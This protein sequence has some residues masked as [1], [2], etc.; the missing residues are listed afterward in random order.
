MKL[1]TPPEQFTP[2]T[3]H[4][5]TPEDFALFASILSY[6]D[7]DDVDHILEPMEVGYNIRT[8][9]RAIMNG[10][11]I[12]LKKYLY[13][14]GHDFNHLDRSIGTEPVKPDTTKLNEM[15]KVQGSDGNWNH[16]PYMH[17]MYNGM[18]YMLSMIEERDPTFREAPKKW[19]DAKYN[20]QTTPYYLWDFTND[21][22]F[23]LDPNPMSWWMASS[24]L[25]LYR[26]NYTGIHADVGIVSEEEWLKLMH[27]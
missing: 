23:K 16:D 27:K 9:K 15:L 19:L 11:S 13:K 1:T 2:M 26:T 3:I 6:I 21:Q 20:D 7:Q 24:K 18:E 22:P 8:I 5:E 12:D 25:D 4:L 14:F 17:G 10:I